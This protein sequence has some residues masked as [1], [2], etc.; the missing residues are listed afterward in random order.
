MTGVPSRNASEPPAF[1]PA[2][3]AEQILSPD[4]PLVIAGRAVVVREY[5][6][7]ESLEAASLGAALI[8]DIAVTLAG[9]Q[10]RYDRVRPLF[11]K[12]RRAVMALIALAT[13]AD[14]EWIGTLPRP[15]GELLQNTWFAVNCGFFVH[16]AAVILLE[17]RRLASRSTGPTSSSA[18]PMPASGATTTSSEEPGAS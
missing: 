12:H 15:Q 13:G 6:Y 18:S 2:A 10:V 5:N 4:A 16:E 7:A 9:S 1:E 11:A 8:A 3:S 17:D 14:Q